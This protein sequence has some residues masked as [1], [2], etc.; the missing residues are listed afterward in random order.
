MDAVRARLCGSLGFHG[1]IAYRHAPSGVTEAWGTVA[2][3]ML[4][5]LAQQH[6]HLNLFVDKRDLH[7]T[8]WNT[9]IECVIKDTKV[10]RLRH[11]PYSGA[12]WDSGAKLSLS[13]FPVCLRDSLAVGLQLLFLLISAGSLESC[14]SESDA[15]RMELELAMKHNCLIVPIILFATATTAPGIQPS[16]VR[17]SDKQLRGVQLLWHNIFN[18]QGQS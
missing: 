11:T 17:K 15:V 13:H 8:Q 3:E 2:A 7:V 4:S 9:Q 14:A 18:N 12:S 5:Y 10:R 16:W 6:F 1:F